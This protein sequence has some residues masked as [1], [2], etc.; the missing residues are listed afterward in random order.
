M[1]TTEVHSL[2]E[3]RPYPHYPLL[4]KPRWQDGYLGSSLFAQQLSHPAVTQEKPHRV[5]SI[6]CGEI[7]PYILRKWE[8]PSTAITC[9]DLSA[10]SLSRAKFRCAFTRGSVSY[11]QADINEWLSSIP[12]Q[13]LQFDHIEAYGVIHHISRLDQTVTLLSKHLAPQGTIRIMV[14]NA[15]P[16]DWIWQLNRIFR[17]MNLS[18]ARDADLNLARS[19]LLTWAKH[20]PLIAQHLSSIGSRSL[21]NNTRFADTFL[22]PWEARLKV[23]RWLEL[24]EKNNLMAFALY[25]RYAELDDLPNPMWQMPTSKELS[26]R[27]TDWRFENNLELW[28]RAK[29]SDAPA[30]QGPAGDSDIPL[31]F[32]AKLPP[33]QWVKFPETKDLSFK[34]RHDLWRGWLT[35]MYHGEDAQALKWIK[36]LPKQQAQRLARIGAILP[37]QAEATG[38]YKELLAPMTKYL[39]APELPRGIDTSILD[40][41]VEKKITGRKR[42]AIIGRLGKL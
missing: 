12:Q 14:Y 17:Q 21:A 40:T 30:P 38:R 1:T 36:T 42:Q 31:R 11:V 6:G 20:S 23:D 34:V 19:L 10:R 27:A 5:L 13:D 4:A 29:N 39:A 37:A 25:D 8:D 3:R 26:E 22:H 41:L 24:F 28:F 35:A 9:V 2:Y 18:H 33:S 15:G 7:L 16:R 32:K